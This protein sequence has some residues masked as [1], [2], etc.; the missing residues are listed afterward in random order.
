MI[1]AA[2]AVTFSLGFF[3]AA[4][5]AQPTNGTPPSIGQT[6][7]VVIGT[8][9]TLTQ[10]NWN[11][12]NPIQS[13][14]D[15]WEDCD[16]GNSTDCTPVQG[17]A[18]GTTYT[19]QG[20]DAGDVIEVSETATASDGTS[21]PA[22]ST[23]TNEIVPVLTQSPS[24]GQ[25]SG[26]VVGTTVTVSAGSWNPPDATITD[27]WVDC[28]PPNSGDCSP[29]QGGA[30]GSSYQVQNSDIGSAIEVEETATANGATSTHL[31]SDATNEIPPAS[32]TP[33]SITASSPAYVG[34]TVTG[35]PG[36]WSPAGATTPTDQWV[37]CE[38]SAPTNVADCTPALNTPP[39]DGPYVI[40]PSDDGSVIE[41]EEYA[42]Y[43]GATSQPVLSNATS[44]VPQPPANT[45]VP[46][47]TGG[48]QVGDVLSALLGLWTDPDNANSYSY[49]WLDC[50][51]L[52]CS[53]IS[54]AD[55]PTYTLT[56]TD[57]A[58][59]VEVQ[60]TA[61]NPD[62]GASANSAPTGVVQTTSSISLAAAP[63][64]PVVDQ[65]VTIAALVVSG[66]P[67]AW[68]QGSVTFTNNGAPIGG[69]VD[70]PVS[71]TA[72]SVTVPCSAAFTAQP[73]ELGATFT[74]SAGA[75]MLGS[76]S[77]TVPVVIGRSS[78]TTSLDATPTVKVG[79]A[80]TYTATVA[81]PSA[82]SGPVRPLGT[83]EFLDGGQAIRACARQAVVRGG[84]SCTVTYSRRGRHTIT[85]SYGGNDNFTG[86]SSPART[87]TAAAIR[88]EGSITATMQWTFHFTPTYTQVL[89]MVINGLPGG[90]TVQM[91]C[92]GHGCPFAHRARSVSS[93]ARCSRRGHGRRACPVRYSL[94]G[95]FAGRRLGVGT[96]LTIMLV[97]PQY[98][99]KY[100]RFTVL[101][102]RQ[103]RVQISCL[104][105]DSTRP[106]V[107][108]RR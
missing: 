6:T 76:V 22:S 49:Q 101:A 63:Q 59:T 90:S 1:S 23:A 105:V 84:A 37:D 68:P 45:T 69:C 72:Q 26:V 64:K 57:V 94:T 35:T 19:V 29:V 43:Q 83:V 3:T 54:G 95:T 86:S 67:E 15:T 108:C 102:R 80:T 25:T 33:P 46:T 2:V 36:T 70:V 103:P 82:E 81:P 14:N 97:R 73:A 16:P 71:P 89:A 60:V 55:G 91:Q 8:Q 42:S 4:A 99:G 65:T 74:P 52:G 38:P 77:A 85:A 53:G 58:D 104:A 75:A 30:T 11:D 47:V 107:G 40:Q 44:E 98:I 10:G 100:Y 106:G 88:A 5:A 62:G 12:A 27:S 32:S 41:L 48:T 18:T 21:S 51:G 93:S 61:S 96:A 34:T 20:S 9:L 50:N 17:G 92:R 66:A 7:G 56:D 13:I 87:V 24:I 78:T 28:A 31:S 39:G 79:A